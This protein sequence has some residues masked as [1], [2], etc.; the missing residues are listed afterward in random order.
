MIAETIP[1]DEWFAVGIIWEERIL[2]F[3]ERLSTRM[4]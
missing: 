1:S 4:E 2:Y 3:P